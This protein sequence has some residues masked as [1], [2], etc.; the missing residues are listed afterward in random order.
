MVGTPVFISRYVIGSMPAVFV[1][2]GVGLSRFVSTW[3]NA[4][5][6]AA[7]C[8]L[9]SAVGLVAGAPQLHED[10]RGA[11]RYVADTLS[12]DGCVL[13]QDPGAGSA[14]AYYDRGRICIRTIADGIA[15]GASHLLIVVFGDQITTPRIPGWTV[16]E[17]KLFWRLAIFSADRQ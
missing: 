9:I 5:V 17:A 6:V 11:T 12:S 7:C 4:A 1:L 13:V 14:I 2:A 8:L 15:P 10:W 3:R 16:S